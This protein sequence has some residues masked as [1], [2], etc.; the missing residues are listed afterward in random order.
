MALVVKN[1]PAK[2]GDIR[3]ARSITGSRR[4]PGGEHGNS[5][6]YSGLENPMAEEPGRLWFYSK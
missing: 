1:L 6:Q 3:D 4:S 5:L 2:P